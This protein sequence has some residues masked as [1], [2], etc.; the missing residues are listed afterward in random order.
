MKELLKR[1]E[2]LE[3]RMRKPEYQAAFALVRPS[4]GKHV[5]SVAVFDGNPKGGGYLDITTLCDTKE[6]AFGEVE[7][8]KERYPPK[9]GFPVISLYRKGEGNEDRND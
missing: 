9:N 2:T 7:R 4:E 5:A 3:N 6:E 8:A 1:L